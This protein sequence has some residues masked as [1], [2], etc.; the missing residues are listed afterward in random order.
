MAA[1][2]HDFGSADAASDLFG[3]QMAAAAAA[4]GPRSNSGGGVSVSYMGHHH[5]QHEEPLYTPPF[6]Y[7]MADVQVHLD[8]SGDDAS[9]DVVGQMR[10]YEAMTGTPRIGWASPHGI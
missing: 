5:Q 2:G 8:Y 1:H 3:L 10:R 7:G 9:A 6:P 4:A